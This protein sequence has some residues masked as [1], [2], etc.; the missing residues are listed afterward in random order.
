MDNRCE[1]QELIKIIGVL[2]S[3]K[4]DALTIEDANRLLFAPK[5][6]KRLESE[7]CSKLIIDLV[8]ECCE[9]ENIQS[10]I[11]D[12]LESNIIKLKERAIELLK[13]YNG[14]GL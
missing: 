9:L 3:L 7:G 12:K 13:S 4:S 5:E 11:P 6:V 2:D 10:L 8:W 14:I 1:Q